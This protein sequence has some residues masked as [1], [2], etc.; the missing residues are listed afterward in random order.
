MD[1]RDSATFKCQYDSYH[2]SINIILENMQ[3]AL[4]DLYSTQLHNNQGTAELGG[5]LQSCACHGMAE[6]ATIAPPEECQVG[7][8]CK[9]PL[10]TPLRVAL[11]I[12]SNVPFLS[13]PLAL[14]MPTNQ[15]LLST[16]RTLK[17]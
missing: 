4:P 15:T 6:P 2:F 5:H 9:V 11:S 13:L 1:L 16:G 3:A 7:Q 12:P 14:L 17:I 10:L 8:A